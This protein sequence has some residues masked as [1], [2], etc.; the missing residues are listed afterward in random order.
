MTDKQ[1]LFKAIERKGF[2][3][4]HIAFAL[5]ISYQSFLNKVNGRSEFTASEIEKIKNVLGLTDIERN[6]I[7]FAKRLI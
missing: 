5:N 3:K 1:A 2:F 7:F 6:A 4:K